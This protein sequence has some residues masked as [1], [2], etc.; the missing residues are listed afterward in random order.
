M[1]SSNRQQL[2]KKMQKTEYFNEVRAKY[3][4]TKSHNFLNGKGETANL[5]DLKI[6]MVILF[7]LKNMYI[8][9]LILSQTYLSFSSYFTFLK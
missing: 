8:Y 3:E 9:T 2:K 7:N 5:I 1:L 4:M 6:P